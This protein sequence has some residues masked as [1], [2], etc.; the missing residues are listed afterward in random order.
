MVR[1]AD[2]VL[3]QVNDR[4]FTLP[5]RVQLAGTFLAVPGPAISASYVASNAQTVHRLAAL[6]QRALPNRGLHRDTGH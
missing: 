6:S 3:A 2:D 1:Q 5:W 4:E